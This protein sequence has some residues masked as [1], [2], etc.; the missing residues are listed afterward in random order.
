[1]AKGRVL[2]MQGQITWG[3]SLPG[4]PCDELI[5]Q[6]KNAAGSSSH[7]QAAGAQLECWISEGGR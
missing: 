4:G 6:A 5:K 3:K 7:M 2:V 1:M